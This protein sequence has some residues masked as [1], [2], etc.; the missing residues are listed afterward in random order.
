MKDMRKMWEKRN[1]SALVVGL[2]MLVALSSVTSAVTIKGQKSATVDNDDNNVFTSDIVE[3]SVDQW[4]LSPAYP[5]FGTAAYYGGGVADDA[6][7]EVGSSIGFRSTIV[8]PAGGWDSGWWQVDVGDIPGP[9]WPEGTT[10]TVWINGTGG[11]VG[12]KGSG[13]GTVDGIYC[14][15]G[16]I[17]LYLLAPN[18][19]PV[20]GSPTPSN[21]SIINSADITW[22]IPISDPDGDT[23]TWSIDCSNGQNNSGVDATN[24]T[25]PLSLTDL[26]NNTN[27]TIWVIATDPTPGSNTSTQGWFTFTVQLLG[28]LPP[29][30]PQKPIGSTLILPGIEYTFIT[31]TTDPDNDQVY[32]KWSWGDGAESE[33]IGPYDSGIECGASHVWAFGGGIYIKVKAK[34][35]HGA[36]TNWSEPT[37][38]TIQKDIIRNKILELMFDRYPNAFPILRHLM[39]Y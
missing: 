25:K 14:D 10:F 20:F 17:V 16:Q 35:S 37:P 22:S 32:Y 30:I 3:Q 39:G 33:W 24:G 28:N 31:T 34:D 15:M 21:G 12:W 13:S 19:P 5:I 8:G 38:Y 29:N 23:F 9:G 7:V 36:E 11:H 4:I 2:M 6:T 1:K 26:T 27:Y 18:N